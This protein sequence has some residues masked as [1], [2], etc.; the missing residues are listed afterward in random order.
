MVKGAIDLA[1]KV[2]AK[3]TDK[4]GRVA[5]PLDD[6]DKPTGQLLP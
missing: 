3:K 5:I 2:F 6:S 4:T 1:K